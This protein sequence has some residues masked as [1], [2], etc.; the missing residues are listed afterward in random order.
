MIEVR[1]HSAAIHSEDIID[2]YALVEDEY[3][4]F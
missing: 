3:F 4:E 1:I 2:S